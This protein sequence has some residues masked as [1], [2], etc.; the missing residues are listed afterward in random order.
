MKSKI[1]LCVLLASLHYSS[2]LIG[3][4]PTPPKTATTRRYSLQEMQEIRHSPLAQTR[5][6]NLSFIPG[7]TVLPF[8]ELAAALMYS[9]ATDAMETTTPLLEQLKKYHQNGYQENVAHVIK[10]AK[11]IQLYRNIDLNEE[12]GRHCAIL[13]QDQ[14]FM[15]RLEA[16]K[17]IG[18]AL[19]Q[20]FSA[21]KEA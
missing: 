8:H 14:E 12:F 11:E 17:Q 9:I 5:P 20:F 10:E 7:V 1:V 21:P 2:T 4:K 19:E 16:Q 3:M 6:T 15:A 13:S 18:K